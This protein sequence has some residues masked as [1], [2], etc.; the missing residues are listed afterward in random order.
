[1]SALL[2]DIMR[3]CERHKMRHSTFGRAAK[4]DT[5][6]IPDMVCGRTPGHRIEAELREFMRAVEAGERQ[7]VYVAPQG[8]KRAVP[9]VSRPRVEAKRIGDC[10]SLYV[11]RDPCGR[12][13]T[14]KDR[15][16]EAGCPRWRA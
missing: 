5:K 2:L 15:H 13:G 4:G 8:P 12:C 1:M 14:R 7:P 11:D 10:G 16:D 3:F 6:L 9:I